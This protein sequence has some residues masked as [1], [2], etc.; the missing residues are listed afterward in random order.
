VSHMLTPEQSRD[1]ERLQRYIER[2]QLISHMN[3]TK[4]RA[5]I[6]AVESIPDFRAVFRVRVLMDQSESS[7]AWDSDFSH[8]IPT[9]MFIHWLEINPVARTRRGRLVADETRD[10]T[11]EI[12]EALLRVRTPFSFEGGVIRI[13]GYSQP[14]AQPAFV[15]PDDRRS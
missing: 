15:G 7:D 14:G 6:A 4:W 13:W 5:A 11:R 2:E 3:A 8:H 9:Y 1:L 10:F 12:S